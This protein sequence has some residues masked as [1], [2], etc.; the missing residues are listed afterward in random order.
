M[1]KL[2]I[3]LSVFLLLASCI[4]QN[5]DRF[6][7]GTIS[8]SSGVVPPLAHIHILGFGEN[9]YNA[10]ELAEVNKDG[11]FKIKLPKETYLEVMFSAAGCKSLLIPLLSENPSK[12]I[13]LKVVLGT[14][15]FKEDLS[16]LSITGSWNDFGFNSA[17]P[18]QK[19]KDGSYLF[20]KQLNSKSAAYQVINLVADGR[21]VNGPVYDSLE[22]DGGGDYRSIVQTPGGKLRLVFTPS[23]L[24]QPKTDVSESVKVQNPS[25]GLDAIIDLALKVRHLKKPKDKKALR[26]ELLGK[27]NKETLTGRYFALQAAR[28]TAP[29]GNDA[30]EIFSKVVA[31]LPITD[32]LWASES[33]GTTYIFA[34]AMGSLKAQEL[35]EREK[36]NITSRR[37]KA[38]I[39]VSLGVR[40]KAENNIEKQ[41]EI[42]RELTKDYGDIKEISYFVEQLNP[43][44]VISKGNPVPEF[45]FKLLNSN[46][47]VSNESLLGKYYIM[48]FWAVWCKPCVGEMP[49]MHKAFKKFKS[50]NFTILSLSFDKEKDDVDTFRR[51]GWKMPWMH[52]F[53]EKPIRQSVS[54]KF[55]IRGIPKPILVDPNGIIIATESE[56]RGSSLDE[57][58]TRLIKQ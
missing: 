19:Q 11:S 17:E 8:S 24:T 34:Q 22:Y 45:S 4:Q 12:D 56:L 9:P 37:V 38:G 58:L 57:T 26:N 33:I 39:L 13:S 21:S 42:Y 20:E 5:K 25:Q 51:G 14:N 31:V 30:K 48:D 49:V 55:E 52:V 40:A 53:L 27:M 29:E 46:K 35:F 32:P 10:K 6:L 54:E 2:F 16:N 50:K 23:M 1:R 44:Q 28:L 43:E 15:T 41:S 18:M 47:T 7:S 3:L 36:N